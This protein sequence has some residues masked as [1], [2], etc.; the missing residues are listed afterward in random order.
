[1]MILA[2]TA[3]CINP[4]NGTV[5][6]D[7][8]FDVKGLLQNQIALMDSLQ[9]RLE[10][11]AI[12]EGSPD[13][14]AFQPDSL[15]WARELELFYELDL[16]KTS[17]RDKYAIERTF[18]LDSTVEVITYSSL[19]EEETSMDHVK[20]VLKDDQPTLLEG[21]FDSK[22][23]LFNSWRNLSLKFSSLDSSNLLTTYTIS[24]AQK[25]IWKDTVYFEIE[26]KIQY[27]LMD[28]MLQ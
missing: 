11:T 7:L 26:G 2:L 14:V 24:G 28:D 12:L 23:P 22:S 20:I 27:P 9:P 3:S 19:E 25:M 6:V 10:K 15:D 21:V 17:L 13:H 8:Y 5:D 4:E 18:E 16:N 1:M